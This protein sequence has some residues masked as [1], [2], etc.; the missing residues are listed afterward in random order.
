MAAV[1]VVLAIAGPTSAAEPTPP[2]AIVESFQES[3][4]AVMK[5]AK[6]LG[7]KGRYE[8]LIPIIDHAFHLPLMT[9]IAASSH[10]NEATTPQRQALV[11]AFRRM[12]VSTLATLFDGYSGERFAHVGESPGPQGT[13]LVETRLIKSDNSSNDIAYVAKQIQNRWYLID[14]IV[15]KGI[16]ELNVR[17]SEYRRVLQEHGVDGLI[18]VLNAKADE[19]LAQK[20][21]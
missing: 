1:L 15:D 12:S 9:H 16:S 21:G 13:L 3:L 4:I 19:L 11:A 10:W 20:S 7:V 8:R 14:V 18:R 17:R 6:V 2:K 5:E